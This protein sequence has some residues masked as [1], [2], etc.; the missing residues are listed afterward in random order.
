MKRFG[1]TAEREMGVVARSVGR[2]ASRLT[3]VQSLVIATATAFGGW[4][5]AGS[6]IEASSEAEQY[7]VRLRA[8][9]GSAAEGNRLFKDMAVYAGNVSFEYR[10]IMGA[11]TSLAGVMKGGVEEIKEWMPLVGD[12]A[13]V[14]G[15]SIQETTGQVIRMYSAGAASADMFRERGI[16]AMMG[17]K[18]GVSYT[19]EE[20]RE[21]MMREWQKADSQFYGVTKNLGS[22]WSGLMSMMADQ[23]FTFRTD[24]MNDSGLFDYF[25]SLFSTLIGQV[26]DFRTKADFSSWAQ[27]AGQKII[28]G[29]ED[30]V[31][32]V[33][34]FYDT[35]LPVLQGIKDEAND[36]WNVYKEN[37]PEWAQSYGLLGAIFMGK[38]GVAGLAAYTWLLG[39]A[40]ELGRN[41][42]SKLA[43]MVPLPDV[44]EVTSTPT[45]FPDKLKKDMRS[46]TAEVQTTTNALGT[47][48]K[49]A[50]SFFDRARQALSGM[51]KQTDKTTKSQK[52]LGDSIANTAKT[53][54][55][56]FANLKKEWDKITLE[57]L[58]K[59]ERGI[60]RVN[61]Q[62]YEMR[63]ILPDIYEAGLATWEQIVA[64]DAELATR[65]AEA[66]A[67]LGEN[68]KQAQQQVS[69]LQ[70]SW[71]HMLD[72]MQDA[73]ADFFYDWFRGADDGFKNLMGRI[74][75]Y[76]VRML[77]E[78]AA[79]AIARPILISIVGSVA[80]SLGID[81]IAE[82]AGLSGGGL[83]ILG[84]LQAGS[85]L[86]SN[87]QGMAGWDL[88][89]DTLPSAISGL[90][91]NF[92][93]FDIVADAFMQFGDWVS[94]L[95]VIGDI[96]IAGVGSAIG[97][98][99]DLISGDIVGAVQHGIGVGL[100][101]VNP[102]LGAAWELGSW[103]G[104]MLFGGS[105]PVPASVSLSPTVG[106]GPMQV[107]W[108]ANQ[109][110]LKNAQGFVSSVT[111]PGSGRYAEAEQLRK[112]TVGFISD[113]WA[114]WTKVI[115]QVKDALGDLGD[116]WAK[117]IKFGFGG[118]FIDQAAINAMGET[119]SRQMFTGM[120]PF[121]NDA[122]GLTWQRAASSF[123]QLDV[124]GLMSADWITDL[125]DKVANL[126]RLDATGNVDEEMAKF[127]NFL[128]EIQGIAGWLDGVA[129]LT[130]QIDA[131][132]YSN[133]ISEF[134][135]SWI[136]INQQFDKWAQQLTE[137]GVDLNKYTTVA[138]GRQ[139][140]LD[141]LFGGAMDSINDI[142]AQHTMTADAYRFQKG[143]VEAQAW[144]DE[145]LSMLDFLKGN[146]T[147]FDYAAALTD[148]N[149]AMEYKVGDLTTSA[150]VAIASWRDFFNEMS[151]SDLSPTQSLE[152]F[153]SQYQQLLSGG[154]TD[155]LLNFIKSDY[156][157]YLKTY[158][159]GT[160]D[161]ADRYDQ[162][163][164]DLAAREEGVYM[165]RGVG[166][167]S[168]EPVR[169]EIDEG[170]LSQS[171][172]S[173]LLTAISA[174]N[175]ERDIVIQV[176][177]T[178]LA[179]FTLQ[180]IIASPDL[181]GELLATIQGAS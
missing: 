24:F 54:A 164:A 175:Q 79:L 110:R 32:G 105:K 168:S 124:W 156:L 180:G 149:L 104:N 49:A 69:E 93:K 33:A 139:Q 6:F 28:A 92:D 47:A 170:Q 140:A 172:T 155:E 67:G 19:A 70:Q 5:V 141:T 61:R 7:Q 146:R 134:E 82:A 162:I 39:K 126:P 27:E 113:L 99:A 88:L 160:Q 72:N 66:I 145:Q 57:S 147:G 52:A 108:N 169:I 106:G 22:S 73:G 111:L 102:V 13:A 41:I 153:Q 178:E 101:F 96:G 8:L 76:F 158:T 137:L 118:T 161:Y 90:L 60:E 157:P 43:D 55:K 80:G 71:Q 36:L 100:A 114:E 77:A 17:F 40:N 42:G 143:L 98:I 44:R 130:G 171:L 165:D 95:P 128:R 91:G 84:G 81:A 30:A 107:G 31:L 9:L 59:A 50:A 86:W 37:I 3:S 166:F 159:G 1:T 23:W 129:Q 78:L 125:N 89:T 138:V 15:L 20:T 83:S 122:L 11:A 115:T 75:D 123:A 56:E 103:F 131:A 62:Y 12:L 63:D 152:T 120:V 10:E 132:I 46:V 45:F 16:L 87:L 116:D 181:L 53:S 94:N 4:R 18:A 34:R 38:K 167:N 21:I 51:Q 150:G 148:L 121:L 179:R 176:G 14:T 144:Y 26:R 127:D 133:S 119:L 29:F 151:I 97:A 68:T 135:K 64:M 85:S 109:D 35:A 136:G 174:S 177:D 25:K 163:M 48:E 173:A 112:Q 58:P 74:K 2:L 142:I 117:S 154:L 65:Q